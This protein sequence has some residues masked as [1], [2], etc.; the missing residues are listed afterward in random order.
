MEQW[1]LVSTCDSML[2]QLARSLGAW[3]SSA[4]LASVYGSLVA[5]SADPSLSSS[6]RICSISSTGA[7]A[8][9]LT[10]FE[11]CSLPAEFVAVRC[12]RA[13]RWRSLLLRAFALLRAV[14]GPSRARSMP[15]VAMVPCGNLCVIWWAIL[16][17]VNCGIFTTVWTL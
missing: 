13:S 1:I 17:S 6:I 4:S 9:S 7:P 12:C 2:R 5:T 15:N 11:V 3:T 16:R 8:I 14:F 10:E